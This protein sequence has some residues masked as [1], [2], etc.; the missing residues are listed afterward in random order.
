MDFFLFVSAR[1]PPLVALLCG[2][3]ATFLLFQ[4]TQSLGF[5]RK[6]L[7]GDCKAEQERGSSSL[8]DIH[9]VVSRGGEGPGLVSLSRTLVH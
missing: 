7:E 1:N 4:L 2:A 9:V 8:A 5:Q 6:G 3:G